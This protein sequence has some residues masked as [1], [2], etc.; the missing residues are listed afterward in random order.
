MGGDDSYARR[1]AAGAGQRYAVSADVHRD[2]PNAV[3][4]TA[5]R[6]RFASDCAALVAVTLK[7]TLVMSRVWPA[8]LR[9]PRPLH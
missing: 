2:R 8:R 5:A 9:S 6:R 3:P 4:L 1:R 7:W